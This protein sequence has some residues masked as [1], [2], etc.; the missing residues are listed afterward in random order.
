MTEPADR[1]AQPGDPD[2]DCDIHDVT[3][4]AVVALNEEREVLIR[5]VGG[6]G[7]WNGVQVAEVASLDYRCRLPDTPDDWWRRYIGQLEEWRDTGTLLRMCCAP[8]RVTSLVETRTRFL[9]LPRRREQVSMLGQ[10]EIGE[11]S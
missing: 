4:T 3:L 8:G 7:R 5:A 2:L 9:L 1:V 6:S 11:G 10:P